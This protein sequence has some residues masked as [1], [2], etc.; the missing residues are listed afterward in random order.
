MKCERRS[1]WSAWVLLLLL[2]FMGLVSTRAEDQSEPPMPQPLPASSESWL[3][4]ELLQTDP[5]QSFDLLWQTLKEELTASETDSKKLQELLDGL[6]IE[7][8]GLQFSLTEST[9]LYEQ[10]E[11]ARMIERKAAEAKVVDAIL[12]SIEA[13]KEAEFWRK[14]TIVAIG[15]GAL[16]WLLAIF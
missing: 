2:L 10:S 8:D 5:W 11:E 12:R 16:G 6:L 14:S 15:L 7:R 13:Q 3:T 4:P 9:R 1:F